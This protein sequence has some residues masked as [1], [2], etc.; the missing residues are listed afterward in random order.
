MSENECTPTEENVRAAW[1]NYVYD[2]WNILKIDSPSKKRE[3]TFRKKE[4]LIQQFDRYQCARDLVIAKAER[5]RI[6]CLLTNLTHTQTRHAIAD[7]NK[8]GDSWNVI[9]R[10][11][12]PYG[13]WF[14]G[15]FEEDKSV[16]FLISLIRGETA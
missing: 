16:A 8:L 15:F 1:S 11:G 10:D 9:Y 2:D 7:K 6:V 4:E 5:E 13:D 14:D 12:A 3:A